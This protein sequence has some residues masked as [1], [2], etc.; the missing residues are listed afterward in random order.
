VAG[1][2]RGLQNRCRFL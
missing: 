1:A 2:P